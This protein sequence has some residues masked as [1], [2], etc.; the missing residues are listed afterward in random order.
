MLLHNDVVTDGEPKPSSFS[1]GFRGEERVEHFF[2]DFRRN[3][4]AVIT[5]CY[6]DTITEILSC[7]S[8]SWL[9]VAAIAFGS[10]FSRCI[11]AIGD[12][13]KQSPR[14]VLWED[15]GLAGSRVQE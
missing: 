12:Q 10:A 7:G 2:L 15:V 11:E 6:L 5:N 14:D 8:Q 4:G 3:A 9:V 1:S 13:I